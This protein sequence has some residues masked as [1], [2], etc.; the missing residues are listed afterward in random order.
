L[1]AAQEHIE[2]ALRLRALAEILP[3]A[4]TLMIPGRG[5]NLAVGDRAFKA[6][7]LDFLARWE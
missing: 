2:A 1:K 6:G 3:R 5:H 7:A 4:E